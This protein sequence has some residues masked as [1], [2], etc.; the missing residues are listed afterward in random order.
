MLKQNEDLD[1]T[2]VSNKQLDEIHNSFQSLY[3]DEPVDICRI[4]ILKK[5][6]DKYYYKRPSLMDLFNEESNNFI[7][8]CYD[9]NSIMKWNID[10]LSN[11]QTCQ[12]MHRM[13]MFAST[14]VAK[15]SHLKAHDA[16]TTIIIGIYESLCGW[17]D[18]YLEHNQREDLL[19]ITDLTIKGKYLSNKNLMKI[20]FAPLSLPFLT[21]SQVLLLT[22]VNI[23]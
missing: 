8:N 7:G 10:G 17:W 4:I 6:L 13:L 5:Y 16:T 18:Y 23:Y 20:V 1:E 9:E 3:M 2:S 14:F 11:Y 12:V 22:K 15:H 19:S 21:I